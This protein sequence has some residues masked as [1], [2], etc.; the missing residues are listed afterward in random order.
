MEELC[1]IFGTNM[2][3]DGSMQEYFDKLVGIADEKPFECVGSVDEV[4]AAVTFTIKKMK[5][6]GVKLPLL[7][8]YYCGT[9]LYERNLP[10]CENYFKYYDERNLLPEEFEEALQKALKENI[11][12]RAPKQ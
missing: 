1:G 3:D 12:E 9:G 6:S 11:G 7:F 4:N 8:E 2:A 5:A 10:L